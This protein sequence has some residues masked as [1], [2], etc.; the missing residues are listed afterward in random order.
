[1]FLWSTQSPK[2][3]KARVTYKIHVPRR[4]RHRK[5]SRRRSTSDESSRDEPVVV[6]LYPTRDQ[7][8]ARE[9]RQDYDNQS[10]WIINGKS[11]RRNSYSDTKTSRPPRTPKDAY[12][13]DKPIKLYRRSNRDKG[14]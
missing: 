11:I 5:S 13:D 14:W 3:H 7:G 6:D 10:P 8:F 2:I 4:H 9:I 12:Y 1:M